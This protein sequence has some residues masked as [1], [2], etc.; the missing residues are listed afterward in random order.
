VSI[1][2]DFAKL[3]TLQRQLKG[4]ASTDTL[5]RLSNLLGAEA[6]TQVQLGFRA[7]R[8]P[9]GTPWAA[10]KLR[11]G[12]PLLDTGRLRSSFSF[13]NVS[14]NGFQVGTNFIGAAVHQHGATIRPRRAKFLRFRAGR[15]GKPIFAKKAVIPARPMMPSGKLGPIWQ[16]AFDETAKRFVSRIMRK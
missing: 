16:E 5:V 14:R 4:L 6:L 1:R 9:Y 12:K 15:K 3:A 7:S 8:D 2:G 13:Q 10:L 11:G